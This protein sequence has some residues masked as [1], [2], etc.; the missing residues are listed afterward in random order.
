MKPEIEWVPLLDE[1][2]EPADPTVE[3]I[4][5]MTAPDEL[6]AA[7]LRVEQMALSAVERSAL[8][9]AISARASALNIS[10]WDFQPY[11]GGTMAATATAMQDDCISGVVAILDS[12]PG[13]PLRIRLK[14]SESN[15]VSLNKRV[16][17]HEILTD[18]V[19]E[20][21]TRARGKQATYG[22]ELHPPMDVTDGRGRK[23]FRRTRERAV[24][25]PENAFFQGTDVLVDAR[26]IEDTE[27]G[28]KL[29]EDIRAGRPVY[30][31]TRAYG[32]DMRV[33]KLTDGTEVMV[34]MRMEIE[35]WDR[36]YNPAFPDAKPLAVLDSAEVAALCDA[37]Q[38]P[39]RAPAPAPAATNTHKGESTVP[40][41][42]EM[43]NA[44][45]GTAEGRR[46]LAL[47][48]TDSAIAANIRT[49]ITDALATPLPAPAAAAPS[50]APAVKP[51]DAAIQQAVTDA[52]NKAAEDARQK[53]ETAARAKTEAKDFVTGEVK[54]L[55]DANRYPAPVLDSIE[56]AL[57][58]AADKATAESQ[59]KEH[60]AVADS[61]IPAVNLV[62]LGYGAPAG[63]S[64]ALHVQVRENQTWRPIYDSLMKELD[65]YRASQPGET[66]PDLKLR[67]VNKP[68]VDKLLA[69]FDVAN[70]Q[71]LIDAVAT[72][73]RLTDSTITTADLWTQ[74]VVN[75]VILEQV[76]GDADMLQFLGTD[77]F[78]GA[79]MTQGVEY[80][81]A[82]GSPGHHTG[83]MQAMARGRVKT[84]FVA[85]S[86]LPR[87]IATEISNDAQQ[88][89]QGAPLTYN[90]AA[91]ALY[92]VMAEIRRV[93]NI[94]AGNEMLRA[95]DAYGAVPVANEKVVADNVAAVNDAGNAKYKI[96]LVKGNNADAPV[97]RPR[98]YKSFDARGQATDLNETPISLKINNAVVPMRYLRTTDAGV[99][100]IVDDEGVLADGFAVDYEYGIV[101][102][103]EAYTIN[104]GAGTEDTYVSYSY[105]TNYSLFDL[106]LPNGVKRAEHYDELLHTVDDVAAMMGR[107]PRYRE[108]NIAIGS[109]SA[110]N[111]IT[112][113]SLFYRDKSPNGT[114]LSPTANFL[115]NR[116][117]I[118]F[119]RHNTQWQAGDRRILLGSA[120]ATK[121]AV[122][123]ALKQKGPYP[124]YNSNGRILPGEQ[125]YV[126]GF[127]ALITPEIVTQDGR[128]LNPYY[129][130]VILRTS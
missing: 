95:S 103:S 98:T 5:K 116:N 114:V 14:G 117:N 35:T 88:A 62:N 107:H 1:S 33:A 84:A 105:A 34:P 21:A 25:V 32:Y 13:K 130:S 57:V 97:V 55:R 122:R 96:T 27:P 52:L 56:K 93:L 99:V 92:H 102:V 82:S 39:A 70:A 80:Y 108:P 46:Q 29:A 79:T 126:E 50:Q 17:L 68:F 22:E 115:A 47:A 74:A 123:D 53:A 4:E 28:R 91:R 129:H 110:M 49:A 41:T 73:Q 51:D 38:L 87:R 86:A 120:R 43:V 106:T 119:A 118:D 58:D 71:M 24:L 3:S 63:Q 45:A 67:E 89:L 40:W 23:R 11:D 15:V 94:E 18:A 9:G 77:V 76:F 72:W 113:A 111:P 26:I 127:D 101:Y 128:T 7:Y 60:L 66:R 121:Y 104:S 112:Q 6:R 2:Q 59:L 125:W 85:F 30:F 100:E 37:V 90:A 78:Q 61:L 124:V 42:L 109:R 19:T 75:R 48:L 8:H 31:S 54:K 10:S 16:Y 65:E 36:V 64:H 44:L 83:E 81:E 69:R 12:A 20:V